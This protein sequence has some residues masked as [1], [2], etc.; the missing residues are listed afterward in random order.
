MLAL[1]LLLVG[2]DT[3]FDTAVDCIDDDGPSF[4]QRQL[5]MPVLNQTYSEILTVRI[6]NEPFDDRFFYDFALEGALPEGIMAS[7]RINGGRD[8]VFEGTATEL[9]TFPFTVFVAVGGG[10]VD[11]SGLCFTSRSRNF[12]LTVA[13]I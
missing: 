2:C 3:L 8:L 7:Q 12:E 4:V 11:T 9:G 13:P 10:G 5:A 6:D 1:L